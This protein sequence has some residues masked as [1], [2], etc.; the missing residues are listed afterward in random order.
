MKLLLTIE[1][2]DAQVACDTEWKSHSLIVGEH[3]NPARRISTIPGFVPEAWLLDEFENSTITS[4]EFK[5]RYSCQIAT[6][7]SDLNA[8]WKMAST[9]GLVVLHCG[10]SWQAVVAKAIVEG[11]TQIE[12]KR[13]WDAGWIV[14]GYT[15]PL[16]DFIIRLGGLRY[17][18]HKVWVMPTKETWR[19]VLAQMPG[20]F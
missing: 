6:C 19:L 2:F 4:S 5:R 8:L 17:D 9:T 7:H 15:Y 18:R 13:R 10:C 14:G 20:E 12:C 11:V 1:P 3:G 16:R